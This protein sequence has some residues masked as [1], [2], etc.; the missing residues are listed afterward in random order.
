MSRIGN[1]RE[2]TVEMIDGVRY[3]NG[4]RLC[5]AKRDTCGAYAVGGGEKCHYHGG[6]TP[7]G[8]DSPH[9]KHLRYS[10]AL[11]DRMAAQYAEAL[12]DGDL[13]ELRSEAA[14]LQVRVADLLARVD[15]GESGAL[16]A[17]LLK[18]WE[19]YQEALL[20]GDVEKVVP[21]RRALGELIAA[22]AADYEAWAEVS[23]TVEAKRKVVETERRRLNDLGVMIPADRVMALIL[24]VSEMVKA[25]VLRY[26]SDAEESRALLVATSNDI[27]RVLSTGAGGAAES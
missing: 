8:V 21:A 20:L 24:M 7:K 12:A 14:L 22:G 26:V 11:P 9:A 10:K 1:K 2:T 18:S 13:L 17:K 15:V 6:K 27:R 25:N 3:R 4:G 16:W 5:N 19:K 23:K